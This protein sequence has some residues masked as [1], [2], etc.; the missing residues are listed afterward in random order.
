MFPL[1]QS[2]TV[3][4]ENKKIINAVKAFSVKKVYMYLYNVTVICNIQRL[5][6]YIYKRIFDGVDVFHIIH[7]YI[8]ISFVYARRKDCI[9]QL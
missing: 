3:L 7:T 9:H 1:E 2:E 6:I 4:K 8:L 5:F